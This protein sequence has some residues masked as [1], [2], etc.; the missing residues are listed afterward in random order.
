MVARW[1]RIVLIYHSMH[2][3]SRNGNYSSKFQ[4]GPTKF[5]NAVTIDD[6]PSVPNQKPTLGTHSS[7]PN[8]YT[9]SNSGRF[10]EDTVEPFDDF[11]TGSQRARSG[12]PSRIPPGREEDPS[13]DDRHTDMDPGGRQTRRRESDIFP[14]PP[15]QARYQ[16]EESRRKSIGVPREKNGR[17]YTTSIADTDESLPHVYTKHTRR[18]SQGGEIDN[19]DGSHSSDRRQ[20]QKFDQYAG[21]GPVK[22]ADAGSSSHTNVS[23]PT[24]TSQGES[25]HISDED[26]Q[27]VF[28][29]TRPGV[30]GGRRNQTRQDIPSREGS[31]RA[32]AQ[33]QD[34][35]LHEHDHRRAHSREGS[36]KGRAQHPDQELHEH[37]HRRAHSREG[38]G[39]ARAQ[40]PDQDLHG[41]DHRRAHSREGSGKGRMHNSHEASVEEGSYGRVS[42]TGKEGKQYAGKYRRPD[43][44]DEDADHIPPRSEEPRWKDSTKDTLKHVDED[45]HN[46]QWDSELYRNSVTTRIPLD[47]YSAHVRFGDDL[48]KKKGTFV[49]DTL[50]NSNNVAVR[51]KDN[52][53]YIPGAPHYDSSEYEDNPRGAARKAE[54]RHGNPEL[55]NTRNSDRS[56]DSGEDG[57]RQSARRN[58]RLPSVE[59]RRR[60]AL[61][62]VGSSRGKRHGREDP[63]SLKT[64]RNSRF[65]NDQ[66]NFDNDHFTTS[67]L[68]ENR[69]SLPG[70]SVG[71]KYQ[72]K[73]VGDDY[74]D[75]ERSSGR[76]S[77]IGP[78]EIRAARVRDTEGPPR[79]RYVENEKHLDTRRQSAPLPKDDIPLR[80]ESPSYHQRNTRRQSAPLPKDDILERRE[81]PSYHQRDTR[82]Q[83]APLPEDDMSERRD[84]PSYHQRDSRR[85]SAP[86]P[87]DD[88]SE[89]RESPSHHQRD[90][91]NQSVPLPKDDI[92][93]RLESPNYHQRVH[94]RQRK[95]DIAPRFDDDKPP[96]RFIKV[97]KTLDDGERPPRFVNSP[98]HAPRND[99]PVQSTSQPPSNLKSVKTDPDLPKTPKTC[100]P[101]HR[102]S[103]SASA[104][105][106][107]PSSRPAFKKPPDLDD[108]IQM[109]GKPKK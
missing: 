74:D 79:S 83:S 77:T 28:V 84:S 67:S 6:F 43:D 89:R 48:R 59:E 21:K 68:T 17:A 41:Y 106:G 70:G 80:R 71:D 86:L 92:P 56:S 58:P 99:E 103:Q 54:S 90:S 29:K 36:G 105:D 78:T 49:D 15:P 98:R 57:S 69:M 47:D 12:P 91:R 10:V 20:S 64:P 81:S 101:E 4:D 44:S 37:D 30:D 46:P 50:R 45:V 31:G 60:D 25:N 27:E 38:S 51:L 24:R 76:R 40:H 104:S 22:E 61:D 13:F 73:R 8:S 88:I 63:D 100:G 93:G 97:G 14:A 26:E 108:L 94:D 72:G 32:R 95:P 18:E 65:H 55:S 75:S 19:F 107:Q 109:F 2:G 96:P 5:M 87:K 23:W 33:Y 82:R 7:Q 9:N 35:E 42:G 52:E 85:Q 102:K 34:Q 3:L 53:K 11:Q 62:D 16:D 1:I 39:K 66:V